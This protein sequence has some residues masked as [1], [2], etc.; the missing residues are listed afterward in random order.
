MQL[1]GYAGGRVRIGHSLNLNAAET[2][3]T[4][5]LKDH[6]NADITIIDHAGL[7]CFYSEKGGVMV[8]Y[9]GAKKF[10]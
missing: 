4:M 10:D 5:I 9:E 1:N 8:G 3:K 7:C 6:P 2:L